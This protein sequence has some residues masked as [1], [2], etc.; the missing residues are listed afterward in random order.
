MLAGM[1]DEQLQTLSRSMG[2]EVTRDQIAA[3]RTNMEHMAKMQAGGGRGAGV[4]C[5]STGGVNCKALSLRLET[6]DSADC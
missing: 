4:W 1:S 3:G 2:H 5:Q 6:S